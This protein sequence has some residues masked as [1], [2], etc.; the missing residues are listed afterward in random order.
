MS[1]IANIM[2]NEDASFIMFIEVGYQR[3]LKVTFLVK[4][5]FS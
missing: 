5:S 4:K 1:M 3:S 2:I